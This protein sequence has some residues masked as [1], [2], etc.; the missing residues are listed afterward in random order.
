M[1][2]KL[3]NHKFTASNVDE[4]SSKQPWN[5]KQAQSEEPEAIQEDP[6]DQPGASGR[7]TWGQ[8]KRG[9]EKAKGAAVNCRGKSARYYFLATAS[10]VL[11]NFNRITSMQKEAAVAKL[12]KGKGSDSLLKAYIS[13]PPFQ[14]KQ[15]NFYFYS[16]AEQ[17][18]INSGGVGI[19]PLEHF[20]STT[21]DT[22]GAV[23]PPHLTHQHQSNS[24]AV[25]PAHTGSED[26]EE[27]NDEEDEEDEEDNKED[28]DD[29][30]GVQINEIG[31]AASI[32]GPTATNETTSNQPTASQ[33]HNCA[34]KQPT[35]F[36]PTHKSTSDQPTVSQ[37]HDCASEQPTAFWT[38][39][40]ASEQPT[41]FAPTHKSTSI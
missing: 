5:I 27:D 18:L 7:R 26:D 15:S 12:K 28:E 25:Q 36:V 33:T 14:K 19:A 23:I 9:G 4:T 31:A 11:T 29:T 34:S 40:H 8:W 38:H 2:P 35:A 17:K 21:V 32:H 37:T 41:A 22:S 3:K 6:E 16:G 30:N 20:H 24:K 13:Y 39:D 1:P 10:S